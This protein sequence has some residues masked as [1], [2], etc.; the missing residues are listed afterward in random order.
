MRVEIREVT[1]G[2]SLPPTTAHFASGSVTRVV[3]ETEQ[4]PT[5]LGLIATGRMGRV[6][7]GGVIPGARV[8][9]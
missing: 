3:A 2:T 5:V 1:K 8:S 9:S 4:R 6:P 7:W